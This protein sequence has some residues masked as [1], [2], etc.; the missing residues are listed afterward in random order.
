MEKGENLEKDYT[1]Q[2][3]IASLAL[4]CVL[5][6]LCLLFVLR[7]PIPPYGAGMGVELNYG[8]VDE[9]FGDVQTLNKANPSPVKEEAAPANDEEEQKPIEKEE[10]RE[11]EEV[12]EKTPE[13]VKQKVTEEKI[14]TTEDE[15]SKTYIKKTEEK[16]KKATPPPAPAK[17]PQ[18]DQRAVFGSGTSN[19]TAGNKEQIAGNNNGDRPGKVGDQGDERGTV[20]AKALYGNPGTGGDGPG[21]SGGGP[22][23]DMV[24]WMWDTKPV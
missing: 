5:L 22:K 11:E 21:G 8:T 6:L 18:V 9:G 12:V 16:P 7:T 3:I 24:G 10:E 2:S 19:G 15:E 14:I 20:D 13:P 23:L 1:Q 17:K 4:H